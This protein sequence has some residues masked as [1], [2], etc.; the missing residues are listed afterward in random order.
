MSEPPE[1]SNFGQ[2]IL[3][4]ARAGHASHA[5]WVAA[6]LDDSLTELLVAHMPRLS[7]TLKKNLFEGYG[8]F[9]RFATKIDVAYALNLIPSGLRRD[10]HAIRAVR[11]KFAHSPSIIH[12]DTDE[13]DKILRKFSDYNPKKRPACF[14]LWKTRKVPRY[15]NPANK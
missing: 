9:S 3:D 12:F 10:L 1:A 14:L 4:L 8:P 6:S 13:M 7:N 5:M 11:N 2:V 15:F